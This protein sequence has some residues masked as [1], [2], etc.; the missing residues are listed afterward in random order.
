MHRCE[1]HQELSQLD[2]QLLEQFPQC[3]WKIVKTEGSNTSNVFL[4]RYQG[5]D[6]LSFDSRAL[7]GLCAE[8]ECTSQRLK[9]GWL[10]KNRLSE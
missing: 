10:A 4:L 1:L 8:R 2:L 6:V 5:I 9:L 3:N 7:Y